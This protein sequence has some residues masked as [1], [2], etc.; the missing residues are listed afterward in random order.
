MSAT[1]ATVSK[2][3]DI[4][5]RTTTNPPVELA[6]AESAKPQDTAQKMSDDFFKLAKEGAHI[7]NALSSKFRHDT[8]EIVVPLLQPQ[9]N[10]C[11]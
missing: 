8:H 2:K 5:F 1:T 10:G 9:G 11:I 3:A 6:V 7:L 4:I